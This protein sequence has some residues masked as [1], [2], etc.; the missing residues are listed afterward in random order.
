MIKSPKEYFGVDP[1]GGRT[2]I[3]WDKIVEYFYHLEKNS[4]RI[5]VVDAGPTTL[6]NRFIYAIIT[7]ADNMAR[8]DE[9]KEIS[10]TLADPKG[11]SEKE[12]SELAS[13]GKA[14]YVQTH[15]VHSSE[16]AGTQ[17]S[18]VFAYELI[19][20][21]H[22]KAREILDNVIFIMIPCVNPDGEIMVTNWYN[23]LLG[24]EHEGLRFPGMYHIYARHCNN[25]DFIHENLI[26]TKYVN[27][28]V[29]KEWAPQMLI[30]HHQQI[31]D[32][33]RISIPPCVDP[34]WPEISSIGVREEQSYGYQLACEM[35][36]EGF[37]GVVAGDSWYNT[38]PIYSL[39]GT[40]K[41]SN[42][43][44]MLVETA[45]VR[46]ASPV[47]VPREKLWRY[48][49]RSTVCPT[50]WQ[51]GVWTFPDVIRYTKKVS[52]SMI[53]YAARDRELLLLR[54]A[55]KAHEQRER[56]AASRVKGYLI[57][58]AQ[59]DKGA[60]MRLLHIMDRHNVEYSELAEAYVL[61]GV[62]YPAG[63]YYVSFAQARYS[64]VALLF[65]RHPY[66]IEPSTVWEDGTVHVFD[67]SST[68]VA[69]PLGIDTVECTAEPS[70][71]CAPTP[72]E[73]SADMPACENES[74]RKANTLLSDG[75]RVWRDEEGNFLTEEKEGA[76][77]IKSAK[78]AMLSPSKNGS[79][80]MGYARLALENHKFDLSV[81]DDKELRAGGL[82]KYDILIIAGHTKSE[83]E[84][85]DSFK[86]GIPD[87]YKSGLG[88]D[89]KEQIRRFVE[90]GGRLIAWDKS[91]IYAADAFDLALTDTT[92]GIGGNGGLYD[93][94]KE[95]LS[96][97]AILNVKCEKHPLT[98]GM[99]E[100]VRIKHNS[101]PAYEPTDERTEIIA[102]HK[103]KDCF[104]NGLII[105]EELIRGHACALRCKAGKGDI[106]LYTFDP[107]YRAQAE[108]TFKL[109]FNALYLE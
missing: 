14:V 47:T 49:K 52:Y 17:F 78:A 56:G 99:P 60:L 5:K 80:F 1:G 93:A 72:I 29:N 55:K 57:P 30:D 31:W 74:F 66:P 9:Y 88:R 15:G 100:D 44:S 108:G 70:S 109:V 40:Y 46:L 2:L 81:I 11:L 26:E 37:V 7:S 45:D 101:G 42:V 103:E 59:H 85:G 91:C 106:I 18:P 83:L 95:Y 67:S 61:G 4:D 90:R 92:D 58:R 35:E 89:G 86:E 41:H 8:L 48:T 50:T 34:I 62:T 79:G 69:D 53:S 12:I 84:E 43:Q 25:R 76:H 19:T 98:R 105:G 94:N 28:I 21:K 104:N 107:F 27:D 71:L 97:G 82:D 87:E 75:V 68:N 96:Q 73:S 63:T 36:E 39:A 3:I 54:R 16:P 6:G 22:E 10:R 13:R 23:R 20:E 32:E 102:R 38:F 65:T 64:L 51:G 77:E 24:T 33:N